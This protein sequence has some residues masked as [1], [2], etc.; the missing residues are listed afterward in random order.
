MRL[1]EELLQLVQLQNID[2]Q[3]K[4]LKDDIEIKKPAQLSHLKKEFEEIKSKFAISETKLKELHLKKK[5]KELDLAQREENLL[6]TQGQLYQLKT[7]KEYQAKLNE[8]A[9]VKS[10]ISVSEEELL[11]KL[12]EIDDTKKQAEI[13]KGQLDEKEKA[14]KEEEL[15]I[16]DQIKIVAID[17]DKLRAQRD[18]FKQNLDK[19]I[20]STY[21]NLLDI[22]QGL[23][24]VPVINYNCGACH[25]L[26]THQKVNEIKMY[27]HLVLCDS[28][29]RIFYIPD[30]TDK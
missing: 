13:E 7:N 28:C 9:S 29:V 23:A 8:I 17:V 30:E 18:T 10:D 5:E 21:E 27:K 12:E 11:I 16:Q 24:V 25:L 20:L 2:S 15:K 19:K 6:K 3:I 22:R 1:K 26:L 4:K 14:F